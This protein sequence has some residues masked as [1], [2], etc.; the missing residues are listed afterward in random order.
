MAM[1]TLQGTRLMPGFAGATSVQ[2][3]GNDHQKARA[4]AFRALPEWSPCARCHKPMWKH[5]TEKPDALGRIRSALHY[6]HNEHGGYLGFSHNTCNREAG[7]AKGGRIA[8]AMRRTN[9]RGSRGTG[10][11]RH[12]TP[13]HSRQW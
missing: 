3:H 11:P 7:A 9:R 4:T 8:N 1:H 2:D 5:A 6:D 13:W 10:V 12:G